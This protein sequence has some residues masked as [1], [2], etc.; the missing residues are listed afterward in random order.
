M[1]KHT[2]WATA[3]RHLAAGGAVALW[4]PGCGYCEALQRSLGDDERVVWVDVWRDDDAL[5]RLL[6]VNGDELVP[7]VLVGERALRNPS[8]KQ[9]RAALAGGES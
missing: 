2:K 6:Q 3:E 9:V 1:E 7:T 5:L 8:A 4:R